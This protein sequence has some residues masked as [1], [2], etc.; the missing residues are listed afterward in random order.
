MSP[1][2]T[3]INAEIKISG[4]PRNQREIKNNISPADSA[5]KRK[6]NQRKSA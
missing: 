4:N 6:K 3:Q 2:I 5:D 1:Q